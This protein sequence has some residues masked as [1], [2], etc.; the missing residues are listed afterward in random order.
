VPATLVVEFLVFGAGVWI[1]RRVAPARDTLGRVLYWAFVGT[2][3]IVYVASVFGP[4]PP[5]ERALAITGLLGWLFVAWAYWIDRHRALRI[6][7]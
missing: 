4:P 7:M 2:L 1:Y 5:S 6:A 3:A